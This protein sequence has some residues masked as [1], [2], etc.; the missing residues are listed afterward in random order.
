M[1]YKSIEEITI[2]KTASYGH[3]IIKGVYKG[4]N[5]SVLTTDSECFDWLNDESNKEKHIEAK[6]HAYMKLMERYNQIK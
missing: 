5:L 3:Y 1:K 4:V 6:K 2:E